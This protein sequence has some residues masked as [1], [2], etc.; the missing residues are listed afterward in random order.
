MVEDDKK[1]MT[2]KYQIQYIF[3]TKFGVMAGDALMPTPV[4]HQDFKFGVISFIIK[5]QK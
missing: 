2:L 4:E 5:H 1:I 3:N